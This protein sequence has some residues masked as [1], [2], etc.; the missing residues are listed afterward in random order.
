MNKA[1]KAH[2]SRLADLGCVACY[3]DGNAGT[4]AEIHH[5]RA[6]V[7][8]GRRSSNYAAIPLCPSHHRGLNHPG[9]PSIHLSKR[10]F[11]DRY[12]TENDLL[13]VTEDLLGIKSRG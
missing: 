7:G 9:T 3:L 6:G 4:P 8:M 2:L 1:E 12:G 11:I 13:K 10:A 5:I